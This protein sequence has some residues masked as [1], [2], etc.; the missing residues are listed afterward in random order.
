MFVNQSI[1]ACIQPKITVGRYF[2]KIT[3]LKSTCYGS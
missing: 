3:A 2:F 1:S